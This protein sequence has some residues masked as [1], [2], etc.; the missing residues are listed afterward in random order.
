MS[1]LVLKPNNFEEITSIMKKKFCPKLKTEDDSIYFSL[2]NNN[3]IDEQKQNNE[4]N[5]FNQMSYLFPSIPIEVSKIIYYIIFYYRKLKIYL[6]KI[7][8]YP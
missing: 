6:K 7:K 8:I 1:T 2:N 4:N 3:K 5:T